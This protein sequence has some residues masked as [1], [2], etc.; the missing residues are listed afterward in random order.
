[1]GEGGGRG[2]RER[3]SRV[4]S[5]CQFQYTRMRDG[6]LGGDEWNPG[7]RGIEPS[8]NLGLVQMAV[9]L[10]GDGLGKGVKPRA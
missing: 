7:G 3:E 2:R 6:G 5:T 9:T 8:G 10:S 1:M 4:H